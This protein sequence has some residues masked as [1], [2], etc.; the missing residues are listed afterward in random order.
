[1]AHGITASDGVVTG[2]GI[3][4]WH[5][6]GVT[7][8]E[9]LTPAQAIEH[10][11]LNWTVSLQPLQIRHGDFAGLPVPAMAVVRMDTSRVLGVVGERFVPVQ[12]TDLVAVLDA[13]IENGA[14][15]DTAG[16]LLSGRI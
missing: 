11:Q 9:L 14:R 1:M 7:L 8:P 13:M 3:K 2:R 6:L 10:A 16:S 4:A 12:N 5:G 15:I